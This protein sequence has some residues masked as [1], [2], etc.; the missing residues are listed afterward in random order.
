[1]GKLL[2]RWGVEESG[3]TGTIRGRAQLKGYGDTVR[4]SLASSNGRIA[5]VMPQGT[6]WARNIQLSELDVGVFVQKLF[7]K[8]LTEPVSI[9]CGLIAFTVRNGV[10]SADPI[11]ID[12]K[13][14]VIL[15]R[16]SFNFKDESLNLDVRADGKKFSLFSGQSPVG[17]GGYFAAPSIDPLSPALLARGGAAIGMGAVLSPLAAILAFV[18]VGDAKSAACGPVLSG[19][20]AAAQRTSKGKLRDDVGRGTPSK[21]EGGR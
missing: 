14:N 11:L 18:D 15:G 9:N 13:K 7:E 4:E 5:I 1:M 20:H 6:M 3:T 10:A 16:G 8:K 12:T 17:V 21:E 2:A 19:A